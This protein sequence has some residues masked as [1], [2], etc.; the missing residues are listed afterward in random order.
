MDSELVA[1]GSRRIRLVCLTRPSLRKD[2]VICP[3]YLCL[4]PPS[5]PP[6]GKAVLVLP[7]IF[8]RPFF[9]F[10]MMSDRVFFSSSP[11]PTLASSTIGKNYESLEPLRD[12][13]LVRY[14]GANSVS[15]LPL[16]GS[17]VR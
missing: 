4:L 6:A 9:V 7:C 12:L 10:Q 11:T 13:A 5:F 16:I 1:K 3:T 8:V 2:L 17:K 14:D 15:D